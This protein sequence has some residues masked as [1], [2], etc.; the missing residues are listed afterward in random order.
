VAKRFEWNHVM[1]SFCQGPKLSCAACCG[2]Y[3]VSDNS[4]KTLQALLEERSA[5]F[6]ET[7]RTF[8]GIEAFGASVL[9]RQIG[10]LPLPDF[11]HCP[12][13]GFID[14]RREKPGC[15]L[16][17]KSPGN[18]GR[19]WRDICHYGGFACRTYFCP[20]H[21]HIPHRMLTLLMD[22]AEDWYAYGLVITR[23]KTL[24][25]LDRCLFG[26]E[27]SE[28]L[29]RTTKIEIV[30]IAIDW[31]LNWPYRKDAV[32]D[33]IHY[34][35]NDAEPGPLLP[36]GFSDSA[37]GNAC[38]SNAC[39]IEILQELGSS[40]END[41]QML[42]AVERWASL[43]ILRENGNRSIRPSFLS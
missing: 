3:N 12:F 5:Q 41:L 21:V 20:S 4:R 37:T 2:L 34:F 8:S 22:A 25:C 30:R 6:A 23:R 39:F 31:I 9:E 17:P 10:P 16:H 11:H 43:S 14:S 1:T 7:P 26:Q 15:L 13:I 38:L 28:E 29:A 40:F 32:R 27:K 36:D 18:D 35:Y 24:E 42:E 33:R 19:D